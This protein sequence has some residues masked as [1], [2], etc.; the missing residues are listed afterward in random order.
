M[1]AL[2]SIADLI[3]YYFTIV[4]VLGKIPK[5]PLNKK[6]LAI[7]ATVLYSLLIVLSLIVDYV[8]FVFVHVLFQALLILSLKIIFRKLGFVTIIGNVLLFH[9]IN[10]IFSV[11]LDSVLKIFGVE[12]ALT[13]AYADL[14]VSIVTFVLCAI[15]CFHPRICMHIREML[16]V[17]NR[18]T[19]CLTVASLLISSLT[20]TLMLSN[21]IV[22]DLSAWSILM[23]LSTIL[24]AVVLLTVFPLIIITTQANFYLKK[25]NEAFEA[26]L[27]AQAQYYQNL[28]VANF[29]LRQFRHDFKNMQ[30]GLKTYLKEEKSQEA[31]G[32]LDEARGYLYTDTEN[33]I[34][35]DSGNGIVDAILADKQLKAAEYNTEIVF[36]G[37]VPPNSLSPVDLCVL[38]GNTIDNAVEACA[39]IPSSM[40][41]IISIRSICNCGFMFVTIS[42]PTLEDTVIKNNILESTKE[43][44]H[45]HGYGLRSL[46]KIAKKY[47]GELKLTS[48][49]QM[50]TVSIDL[51]IVK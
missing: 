12:S 7:C 19:K 24:L 4:M 39:K 16:V 20:V 1:K 36:E 28:S 49:N 44:K 9:S 50:F 25:Q 47:D 43:D 14:A 23:R 30:I 18:K 8:I 40:K 31:L 37:S 48:K 51:A 42:N 15:G 21:P 2:L 6:L 22:R 38:F 10:M 3:F 32:L 11:S 13:Y 35:Y 45:L 29:E 26:D 41:K 17:L 34:R 33:L 5:Y 27:E 46:H